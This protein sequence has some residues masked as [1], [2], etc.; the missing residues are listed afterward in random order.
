VTA[1]AVVATVGRAHQF[2][3]GREFAASLGL[4][5]V[6]R[7]SGGKERLGRIPKMG[8]RYVRKLL[9][10]GMTARL[11]QV[12]HHPERSDPWI[13]ALSERKPA[14]LATVAMTNKTAR[15]FWAMLTRNECF[16]PRAA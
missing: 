15:T 6:N 8:D 1:S 16:Q 11:R 9:V 7:S 4:T 3:N 14:R 10:I 12:R 5:P 13:E 2:K